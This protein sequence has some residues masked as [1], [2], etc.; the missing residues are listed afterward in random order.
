MAALLA[1]L[2]S[3][4]SDD[5]AHPPPSPPLHAPQLASAS[6]SA[7]PAASSVL[8]IGLCISGDARTLQHEDVRRSQLEFVMKPLRSQ[9]RLA[10]FF[11]LSASDRATI[12]LQR[13][14]DDYGL[15]GS[16]EGGRSGGD[17][18][19]FGSSVVFANTS[20]TGEEEVSE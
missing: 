5:P 14:R 15:E 3:G 12:D 8:Q 19:G 17:D 1:L 4:A 9:G 20:T 11:V 2:A 16:N 18:W 7:S 6:T 10:T 13:L